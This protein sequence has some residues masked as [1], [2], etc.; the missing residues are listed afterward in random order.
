MKKIL[1][2][3]VLTGLVMVPVVGR[4]ADAAV[5][6][7]SEHATKSVAEAEAAYQKGLA[8]K[9]VAQQAADQSAANLEKAK[10][11]LKLAETTGDQEKVKAAQAALR[12]ASA[13]SA[14][15]A[16]ALNR[17]N[18]LVDRLKTILD[19]AREAAQKIAQAKT[20]D[21]IRKATQ[22]LDRLVHGAEG[23]LASIQDVM[24]PHP[25]VEIIGVTIPATTTSTTQPSPTQVSQIRG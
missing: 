9:A 23:V 12:K 11:D 7:V 20:P 15:K 5:P 14:D 13:V 16:R 6:A 1:A 3:M 17:V 18:G 2:V 10:T 4:S 24:K 22:E 25:H 21:Q 19:R 8:A